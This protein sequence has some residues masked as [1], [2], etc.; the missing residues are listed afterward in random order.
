MGG[1]GGGGRGVVRK[2][3]RNKGREKEGG[4]FKKAQLSILEF[5]FGISL[6]LA[7]TLSWV[8]TNAHAKFKQMV[9]TYR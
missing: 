5:S 9:Q 7:H 1:G 4:I 2:K 6:F 8:K 3:K